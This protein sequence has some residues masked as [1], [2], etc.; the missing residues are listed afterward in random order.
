M[1]EHEYKI[2]ESLREKQ[3]KS[4]RKPIRAGGMNFAQ[5]RLTESELYYLYKNICQRK[6]NK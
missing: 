6:E 4:K 5:P 3:A 2:K 1:T